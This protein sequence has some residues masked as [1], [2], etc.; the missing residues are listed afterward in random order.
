[1]GHKVTVE[2]I[3][4]DGL[5]DELES[6]EKPKKANSRTRRFYVIGSAFFVAVLFLGVSLGV[7]ISATTPSGFPT[8]IEPG[9]M[10]STADYIIFKDISYYARDGTTGA[11]SFNSA[12]FSTLMASVVAIGTG[13]LSIFIKPGDYYADATVHLQRDNLHLIGA[14]LHATRIHINI[15]DVVPF[16]V[17]DCSDVSLRNL[18]LEGGTHTGIMGVY[19]HAC[20][21]VTIDSIMFHSFPN[22]ANNAGI[23]LYE[24]VTETPPKHISITN[25]IFDSC[26]WAAIYLQ[27]DGGASDVCIRGNQFID[28]T[29]STTND[30]TMAIQR[31]DGL[32]LSDNMIRNSTG[33]SGVVYIYGCQNFSVIGNVISNSDSTYSARSAFRISDSSAGTVIG[34]ELTDACNYIYTGAIELTR[35]S[36]VTIAGNTI[37]TITA[38][39][40]HVDGIV[41]EKV[42]HDI[43]VTGNVIF[44]GQDVN[45]GTGIYLEGQTYYDVDNITI[46]GNMIDGWVDQQ[47]VVTYAENVLIS[48]NNIGSSEFDATGITITTSTKAVITGNSIK[49]NVSI[50]F[51]GGATFVTVIGNHIFANNS[52]IMNNYCNNITITNNDFDCTYYG[53][54]HG[55][56]HFIHYNT[57][58]ITEAR[59]LTAILSGNTA[60]TFNHTL[61]T[62]PTFVLVTGTQSEV[63]VLWV[64][65]ITSTQI[66]INAPGTTSENRT[67]YWY[68]E[69]D[70]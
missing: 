22:L 52:W 69:V 29:A 30:F 35:T 15:D 20:S 67:I 42:S 33:N 3:D 37:R 60:V 6:I 21:N 34:N 36:F 40:Y 62:Q 7:M 66:T 44:G 46:T 45:S 5:V 54:I 13:N 11:V 16:F 12:S 55:I 47:I 27:P 32:V 10:V 25:C 70:I 1:M 28:C 26:K 59:G 8:V 65:S 9:S 38:R 43:S 57:G 23:Y 50:E 61:C 2:K 19:L 18:A 53:E 49:A 58:F 17:E 31:I 64:S 48:S 4:W 39:S 14:G 24:P 56:T 63:S 68:A 41:I 51:S